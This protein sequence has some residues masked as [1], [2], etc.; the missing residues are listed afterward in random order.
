MKRETNAC[1]EVVILLLFNRIMNSV[2]DRIALCLINRVLHSVLRERLRERE[3]ESEIARELE[4]ERERE[5]ERDTKFCTRRYICTLLCRP[6]LHVNIL[7]R[8]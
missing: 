1:L 7:R 4:R 5:L 3:F 6:T 8:C 2:N